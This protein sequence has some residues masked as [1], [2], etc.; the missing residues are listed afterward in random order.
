MG[1]LL[2]ER[3]RIE[4][5]YHDKKYGGKIIKHPNAREIDAYRFFKELRRDVAGLKILDFGSGNGWLS[6]DVSKEGAAEVYGIDISK[7]LIE[8]ANQLAEAKG[9]SKTVHFIKMPGENLTFSDNCFDLCLGSAILHHTDLNLAVKNIYRVLKPGGRAIFIEPLNQ[10][11][12][13]KCWRKLTPW[14]RSPA[15]KALINDDLKFIRELFPNAKFHFFTFSSILTEGVMIIFPNNRFVSSI[16]RLLERFDNKL[17]NL[18]PSLG[19]YCAIVVLEIN[20]D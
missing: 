12:F 8:K 5:N 9:F 13:L 3:Q 14:R 16:N 15:E 4:E 11:L 17:L 1:N 10:N 18:F 19:K 6:I 7:E 2:L 20:K